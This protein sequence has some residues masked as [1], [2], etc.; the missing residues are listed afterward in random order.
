MVKGEVDIVK[1]GYYIMVIYLDIVI[2]ILLI[3]FQEMERGRL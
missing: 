1:T 3:T 2:Y